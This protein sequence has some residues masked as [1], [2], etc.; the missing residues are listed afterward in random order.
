MLT[1]FINYETEPTNQR[2]EGSDSSAPTTRTPTPARSTRAANSVSDENIPQS[3]GNDNSEGVKF[4][5]SGSGSSQSSNKNSILKWFKNIWNKFANSSN[6]DGNRIEIQAKRF[7]NEREKAMDD[8]IRG[9]F[10]IR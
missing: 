9:W 7:Q 10:L 4:S 2:S 1:G 3:G 5:I 8:Y 6:V